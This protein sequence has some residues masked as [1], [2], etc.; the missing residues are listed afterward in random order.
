M[1]QTHSSAGIAQNPLLA[2][3]KSDDDMMNYIRNKSVTQI[4]NDVLNA[5]KIFTNKLDSKQK[6]EIFSMLINGS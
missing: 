5:V 4:R 2:A 1:I 6:C 3:V